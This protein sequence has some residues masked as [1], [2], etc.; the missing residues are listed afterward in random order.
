MASNQ[1]IDIT[2]K[3]YQNYKELQDQNNL[4]VPS[5][6]D[7]LIG[8]IKNT[9]T[10]SAYDSSAPRDYDSGMNFGSSVY[11]RGGFNEE[12]FKDINSAR[13]EQQSG[14][15][16]LFNGLTKGVLL[17][18]TTFLDGTIGLLVGGAEAMK[19]G[20]WSGLWDNDF[21][22]AMQA[23]NDWSEEA[24]PNYY[25]Q[26]EQEREWYKNI[27]TANFWGDKFIKNLGFTVGAFYSGN[28]YAGAGRA[29]AKA[30]TKAAAK[31]A[32]GAGKTI[33]EVKNIVG[34]A[35]GVSNFTT[36]AI[37][38]VISA[39][40]EGRIEALN[41]SR[42][43]YNT[44]RAMLDDE[45]NGK[46]QSL[47][48]KYE[49]TGSPIIA[50]QID[51][52]RDIYNKTLERLDEDRKKMGNVD[53]LLNLPILTVGNAI[54]FGKMYAN[55]FRT[56]KRANNIVKGMDGKYAA[57]TT[58]TKAYT[59]AVLNPLAEGNE[60][61]SQGAASRISGNYYADD[62]NAFYKSG[63]DE[64]AAEETLDWWKST[65]QG[66]NETWNDG[67]S[68]EEFFIGTLT[69]A[70]GM[71]SFGKS[72]TQNA[73]LGRGKAVGLNGGIFGELVEAN[74]QI[75]QEQSLAEALNKRVQEDMAG[76]Y[77]GLT[78][79]NKLQKIM[80]SSME[81]DNE[82]EYK[83]AE[84]AQ[85]ISDINMFD[86]AGR[87]DDL[88][89]IINESMDSNWT[90]EEL[91][92]IADN[93][94]SVTTAQEQMEN[95]VA[96]LNK[97]IQ[98]YEELQK[99]SGPYNNRR[100]Q[101]LNDE[102]LTLQ[103]KTSNLSN[104]SDKYV[105]PWVDDKGN[106][107]YSTPEGKQKMIDKL[108]STKSDMLE[109]INRYMEI[110][111]DL[112]ES[113]PESVTDDQL[114]ELIYMQSQ[115]E[116]WDNRGVEM[117][118][119]I[120]DALNYR[121]STLK[122]AIS[123][124]E[125]TPEDKLS[126]EEKKSLNNWRNE[127]NSWEFYLDSPD[128]FVYQQFTRGNKKV[129][130][131]LR[132]IRKAIN[133]TSVIAPG[134]DIVGLD[135]EKINK[136]F[137]DLIKI[138]EH[139][140]K[141]VDKLEEYKKNPSKQ[142]ED[143]TRINQTKE[144]KKKE[145]ERLQR[146][147]KIRG[148]SPS[149]LAEKLANNEITQE[150][151]DTYKQEAEE[152]DLKNITEMENIS[153]RTARAQAALSEMLN[154]GEISQEM[155]DDA[156][157][158][159]HSSSSRADSVE[160]LL[161]TDGESYNDETLLSRPET[162]VTPD[163]QAIRI[164]AAKNTIQQVR[165]RLEKEDTVAANIPNTQSSPQGGNNQ[166]PAPQT[167][168][169]S[170]DRN[171]PVNR[172]G[173]Q[174]Q[175][176]ISDE[177]LNS[178][179]NLLGLNQSGKQ[180]A[181]R[182]IND[183]IISLRR[184]KNQ[185]A[186]DNEMEDFIDE[187]PDVNGG[188]S[189]GNAWVPKDKVKR[190]IS[191]V[192]T[193]S[194]Q[195]QPQE[196]SNSQTDFS[197]LKEGDTVL[198]DGQ[199]LGHKFFDYK[200]GIL[201]VTH[202][203]GMPFTIP[204]DRAST[205]QGLQQSQ[206]GT[207][208]QGPSTPTPSS[209]RRSS[210]PSESE[211]E[212]GIDDAHNGRAYNTSKQEMWDSQ[213]SG[214]PIVGTTKGPSGKYEYWKP[215]TTEHPIHRQRGDNRAYWETLP[216]NTPEEKTKKER[217]KKIHDFLVKAGVFERVD[218]DQVKKGDKVRFA[219]SR[220]L[221][222]DIGIP[223][224]LIVD[225][226]GNIIGDLPIPQDG[227]SFTDLLGFED[228][229]NS[230][231]EQ[232][233][234]STA[235][236]GQDLFVIPN[237]ESTV[238]RM[239][240]GKPLFTESGNRHTLNEISQVTT[241]EG[242]K[243]GLFEL[244]VS[245]AKAG[246]TNMHIMVVPGRAES[247]GL[248]PL[249]SA[250]LTPLN[251]TLGQPFLLLP[252][253]RRTRRGDVERVAVPFTMPVFSMANSKVANSKLGQAIIT[254]VKKLNT[255]L[256]DNGTIGMWKDS[257]R[258]LVNVEDFHIN[259]DKATDTV[260]VT[261]GEGSNRR[262][263]YKGSK[264]DVEAMTNAVLQALDGA[265]FNI[266]RKYINSQYGN[267]SY[268]EMIGELAETNLPIGT[269]HTS[270]DW[271]TINPIVNGAEKKAAKIQS[272]R[273]NPNATGN[274]SSTKKGES[275]YTFNN[276]NYK[277][278]SDGILLELGTNGSETFIK[279]GEQLEAR[280]YGVGLNNNEPMTQ[281]Y[282]TNW[283]M[284]DPVSGK[285]IRSDNNS[286]DFS[287]AKVGDTILIDGQ[288]RGHKF[289]S[290]KNGELMVTHGNSPVPFKVS[291]PLDKV[292][293]VTPIKP[294]R[295]ANTSTT[296]QNQGTQPQ[297]PVKQI[298]GPLRNQ[299]A[300]ASSHIQFD[301][302]THTYTIDRV[303]ADMSVTE[304]T[305]PEEPEAEE[306]GKLG[307]LEVS[308]ILGTED[309]A[310]KRAYFEGREYN[311]PHLTPE[312]NRQAREE[313]AKLKKDLDNI[314]G[315]DEAT[316]ESLYSVITDESL[317]RVAGTISTPEGVK[318]IAGTMD[319]L[320]QDKDGNLWVIDF[321][322]KR[323]GYDTN[324]RETTKKDLS[325]T[326]KGKYNK[327]VSIY[328]QLLNISVPL[329]N[330]K[331]KGGYLA[332]TNVFYNTPNG[333]RSNEVG[334]DTYILE[335]GQIMV[336][337]RNGHKTPLKEH[338][339]FGRPT[340]NKLNPVTLHK[341]DM[342][343]IGR[344]PNAIS[345][346]QQTQGNRQSSTSQAPKVGDSSMVQSAKDTLK[347]YKLLG[348]P[349]AKAMANKM[350]PQVLSQLAGMDE[351]QAK[352]IF[353]K[354]LPKFTPNMKEGD[355]TTL[356]NKA[357]GR[358]LNRL[359]KAQ[360][361]EDRKWSMDNELAKIK[362]ALP[363]LSDKERIRLVNGLIDEKA[364]G[365]FYSGVI[366]L[367]NVAARGTSYH[368]AF[369]FVSQSLLTADELNNLYQEATRQYGNLDD[370]ELEERLA[371]SFREFMQDYDDGGFFRNTFRTL[372]HIVKSLIGKETIINQLFQD[373]RRG[374]LATRQIHNSEGKFN[375][376]IVEEIAQEGL[377]K[378]VE[379]SVDKLQELFNK[380]NIGDEELQKLGD[381]VF[382]TLRKVGFTGRF[383]ELSPGVK[384]EYTNDNSISLDFNT[385]T[386]LGYRAL[387]TRRLAEYILHESIHA[388]TVY[389]IN[390]SY[391]DNPRV[392]KEVLEGALAIRQVYDAIR[393]DSELKSEYGLTNVYEMIS[394]ITSRTFRDKLKKRNLWRRI[395]DGIAKIFGISQDAST[396][397][398]AYNELMEQL[399]RILDNFDYQEYNLFNK[400]RNDTPYYL[401]EAAEEAQQQLRQDTQRFFDNFGISLNDI[402]NFEGGQPKL[403]DALN[404]VIN[405][406]KPEDITEGTGYAIAFMMQHDPRVIDLIKYKL[407][408]NNA[409][410]IRRS[411]RVRGDFSGASLKGLS[412]EV[413]Q[414][415][416]RAIGKDIATELRG[417]Y[418][419][420]KLE[421]KPNSF[422]SKLWSIISDFFSMFTP[423]AK[424]R[425]NAMQTYTRDVANAVRGNDPSVILTS[426]IKPGTT[427][428]AER[429]N[430]AKALRE[431][432]Y[433][434]DIIEALGNKGISLAGSAS[435]ALEGTM[436]RPSEN[437][438]HDIDF[439]AVNYSKDNLQSIISE[440]FPNNEFI[441]EIN[442]GVG[443][444]TVT[445][446]TLDRPFVS[447]RPVS[448][449][450]ITGLYDA[451]TGERLGAWVGSNLVLKRGVKGK[452]LDFFL[453]ENNRKFADKTIEINGKDYLIADYRN[454]MEAKIDWA[455]EKD[456]WDYNR[457]ISNEYS[458]KLE[459]YHKD[460]LMYG[461]LNEEQK[462]YIADRGITI[463]EYNEMTPQ[464][465]ETLFF[466]MA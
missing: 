169:D 423:E 407:T 403:F 20:D 213:A 165:E 326:D 411:I 69:G 127:L 27:G 333:S 309:D 339:N 396:Q 418:N 94:T 99:K 368:E 455:R 356:F 438:L 393:N 206:Q 202:N 465:K 75:K 279:D 449:V 70:L 218:G 18:G 226:D 151:I 412:N 92:A 144:N 289:F 362:K 283:G 424:A 229:Y 235:V 377:Q 441:R 453:G 262:T 71:P 431:N 21:S 405:I 116:N 178:A 141:F 417:L 56:G 112:V 306:G 275:S 292:S 414:D 153:D 295:P 192:T 349:K 400:V 444:Q 319:M 175:Q 50:Y 315:V 312:Q 430:I 157:S 454:A 352:L 12:D 215:Q 122:T 421:D 413:R 171:Q 117:V 149:E 399:N 77:K 394:E 363:Q 97:A 447:R 422:L 216:E 307:F 211:I 208:L 105:G 59:K 338:S 258:E 466:C 227:N 63:A 224:L 371:E 221:T 147:N 93:T 410:G 43:W 6:T 57:G 135:T 9:P 7:R 342:R 445:Y 335:N 452:F 200:N 49:E 268:N 217:L 156:M 238:S 436:Y 269:K 3:G 382:D 293:L 146:N 198:V 435:I 54:Q 388:V 228:F 182:A 41:N 239:M 107:I 463:E 82:K 341:E 350:S 336:T 143:H 42:D 91:K 380:Y 142:A 139:R 329:A 320:L 158:M 391:S 389:A 351:Q 189:L 328:G 101:E 384:G 126:D 160:A 195:S 76:Y 345:N 344:R 429:V 360:L 287:K 62:I 374:R 219:I 172:Q 220:S 53:L 348:N 317:L 359:A 199:D 409:K 330:G 5:L 250:I 263:V 23:I 419:L 52:E 314:F 291:I 150:E 264:T 29:I 243:P 281:P 170:V 386:K 66:L 13:A 427:E 124:Y 332:V 285:F 397:T 119:D 51:R 251:M 390:N 33:G 355:V 30:A 255:M 155:Y 174:Q 212:R 439:N 40:N 305:N 177:L 437:P 197:S 420:T 32:F 181:K 205:P 383:T 385:F 290:F 125:K 347:S 324:T 322:T 36:G 241:S 167:G 310:I 446:L 133:D 267:Q 232:F 129:Q 464:E 340:Y 98:E 131:A 14:I 284:F 358:P 130:E 19:R 244:G 434:R 375:R 102:I 109:Q 100:K 47:I 4:E 45:Y 233:N 111:M 11:D 303:Q 38:S 440:L 196:T 132:D 22:K 114:S 398:T 253:S 64:K 327:Q 458:A 28:L 302:D 448:G 426:D 34:T 242:M 201:R 190:L 25:S 308:S 166:G 123:L 234:N 346:P 187:M 10:P 334:S 457:F 79:H 191:L 246:S 300:E 222:D 185:G 176:I 254:Q 161:D 134:M 230:A 104:Y 78:R 37:G 140:A 73:Y 343:R 163:I 406:S 311:S 26:E 184:L 96:R 443:R 16:Q 298:E 337:D 276:R 106:P 128:E 416:L 138:G 278:T 68:W 425:F 321:K 67:S 168:H 90:D 35:Q 456:I 65:A 89:G 154:N 277:L 428:R 249:E 401:R 44:Q 148:L 55:G 118:K 83:D 325:P 282:N 395:V 84:H 301:R 186:S 378:D 271:F 294:V 296:T 209:A 237:A 193:P 316:G 108:N 223:K 260:S 451:T 415:Y 17:A 367:S 61:I 15:I 408:E 236:E 274:N 194:N 404:R 372:K 450:A 48:Q 354:M 353:G 110:K 152:E 85:F 433:E 259:V 24:L 288:D 80:D 180:S 204:K 210:I 261:R 460:R 60:E 252:T 188:V 164:D 173:T 266:S 1:F 183:I 240:I 2:S 461:K 392:N 381:K 361:N 331:F 31:A 370:V 120:K 387:S 462:D 225:K 136:T 8:H 39:A 313:A 304:W 318:T 203:G 256:V 245:V 179:A 74:R 369:H 442:D 432:P 459:Q 137:D 159:L 58:R 402:S 162:P 280:A 115:I 272:T 121:V 365:Q 257:I 81:E 113:L 364:W 376:N 231:V 270:D 95:D 273:T 299:I 366:T 207:Q 248:H 247:M 379:Y 323:S 46:I 87:L 103:E 373:I 72:H 86:N 265:S 286:S 145:Q 357:L 297:A 88:I 214:E